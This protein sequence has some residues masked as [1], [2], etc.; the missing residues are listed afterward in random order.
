[1][2]PL[3]M[4]AERGHIKIVEHFIDLKVDVNIK[5]YIGVNICDPTN[6]NTM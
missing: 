4:A 1:M 2:S 3:H 6:D 5:D